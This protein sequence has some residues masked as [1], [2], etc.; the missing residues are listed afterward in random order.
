MVGGWNQTQHLALELLLI[1][2]PSL[3]DD[4]ATLVNNYI[5]NNK[6]ETHITVFSNP[7]T[8]TPLAKYII[9]GG[10]FKRVRPPNSSHN[11][12][13]RHRRSPVG[14]LIPSLAP[15]LSEQ[16]Q[17]AWMAA[18]SMPVKCDQVIWSIKQVKTRLY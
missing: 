13:L 15:F 17:W 1:T 7:Q 2:K 8:S 6:P 16:G 3:E 9:L 18:P 5:E 4:H 10:L 12:Y 14:K 11:G